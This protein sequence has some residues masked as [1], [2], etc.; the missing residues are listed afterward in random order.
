MLVVEKDSLRQ[1]FEETEARIPASQLLQQQIRGLEA[2]LDDKSQQIA[3]L[4]EIVAMRTAQADEM[5]RT[6]DQVKRALESALAE[7]E[8][9]ANRSIL[10]GKQLLDH[11][12]KEITIEQLQETS[13]ML[14]RR[15]D[16]LVTQRSQQIEDLTQ[17]LEEAV[18][19]NQDL[20]HQLS[21]SREV[22]HEL[23]ERLQS[24]LLRQQQQQHLSKSEKDA[25]SAA[26]QEEAAQVRQTVALLRQE[27]K[28]ADLPLSFLKDASKKDGERAAKD[29]EAKITAL[30]R[31]A[32]DQKDLATRFSDALEESK[33]RVAAAEHALEERVA[34]Q[35]HTEAV[36]EQ[37]MSA[38]EESLRQKSN[39]IQ[40][41][42]G[43]LDEAHTWTERASKENKRLSEESA[44]A[45]G[46]LSARPASETMRAVE[47]MKRME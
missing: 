23:G 4:K 25:S 20:V 2:K 47:E 27:L 22:N 19:M 11:Q 18:N 28:D 26:V 46:D 41:L 42:R 34:N 12:E 16:E 9:L 44:R 36:H 1:R 38:L 31:D 7:K 15:L 5:N 32:A 10:L 6:I 35:R 24:H 30:Q 43:S 39:L 17:K 33:K 3:S 13:D 14:Q 8:D 21:K 29:F 37:K 40:Q 45:E